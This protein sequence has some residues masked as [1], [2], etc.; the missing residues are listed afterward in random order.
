ML[1]TVCIWGSCFGIVAIK[2]LL[3]ADNLEL[4]ARVAGFEPQSLS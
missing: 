4:S 2:Q 1:H 3:C